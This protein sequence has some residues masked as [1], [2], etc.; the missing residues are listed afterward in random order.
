VK[1][2]VATRHGLNLSLWRSTIPQDF[3]FTVSVESRIDTVRLWWG[4]DTEVEVE[5]GDT[6]LVMP[7]PWGPYIES[8]LRK[9]EVARRV[10]GRDKPLSLKGGEVY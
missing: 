2:S 8:V 1:N 4:I 7:T 9:N 3:F 5:A 6:L 10:P